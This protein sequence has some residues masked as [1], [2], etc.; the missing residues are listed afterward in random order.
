[1]APGRRATKQFAIS[2]IERWLY[3]YRSG[4]LEALKPE[5]R[6]DRGRARDLTVA[7]RELLLDIRR[8]HPDASAR[9]IV[10]TLVLDGRLPK[11]CVSISTVTR[12]YRDAKLSRGARRDGHTRLRWQAEH[13]GALWHGDVCH[14]PALRVGKTTRPLRIHALLDDA[15]RYVVALEARHTERE[16][17]LLDLMLAA[18]R[19]HGAPDAF[20]FDNGATYSGDD[21]RLASERLGIT[22]IHARPYDAPARGKMERFWRTLREGCLDHLGTMT[23][24]HDVQARLLAFLDEHYHRA[25]HGGLFGKTPAQVWAGAKTRL[26]D[27]LTLAAALTTTVRRRVR[28]D[29]TLD[30]RGQTWQLDESFLSGAVVTVAVDLAGA[31]APVVEHDQRRYTLRPVDAV[32]AGKQRRKPP[33][34][35]TTSTVPFDPAGALLDRVAGRPPRHRPEED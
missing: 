17:D 7:Q 1:R 24:L 6:S 29:G 13:A 26:L 16:D 2:T 28:R 15:S 35:T 23:S 9:L 3:A 4:G 32:A 33:T 10:R 25:P 34:P 22:L 5:P 21:L 27:E 11:D 30:V 20:Y 19:R 14:G 8:E 18:L 31:A 12:L